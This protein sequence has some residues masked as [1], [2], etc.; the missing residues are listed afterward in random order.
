MQQ[1]ETYYING[2]PVQYQDAKYQVLVCEAFDS[3]VKPIMPKLRLD[4][5]A[6]DCEKTYRA[7][8]RDK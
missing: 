8:Q 2:N 5:P 3:P 4:L 6:E 1:E 7:L